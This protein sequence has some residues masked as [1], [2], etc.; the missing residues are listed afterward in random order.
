MTD[1]V[2]EQEVFGLVRGRLQLEADL[3][4]VSLVHQLD[5][6]PVTSRS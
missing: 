1:V 6:V 2:H 4:E 3:P 5:A